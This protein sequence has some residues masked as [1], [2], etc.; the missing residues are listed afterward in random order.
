MSKPSPVKNSP[1]QRW[2]LSVGCS[3][4]SLL[5]FSPCLACG[6]FFPNQ[7]LLGSDDTLLSAPIADF[8]HE[9]DLLNLKP[10]AFKSL[11]PADK[12]NV[13]EQSAA[14]DTADL[15]A[16]L[17]NLSEPARSAMVEQY[18]SARAAIAAHAAAMRD[19]RE[20]PAHDKGPAKPA[21]RDVTLPPNLPPEFSLYATGLLA[22]HEGRLDDARAAWTKLLSLP[23]DQRRRRS[24]WAAYMLG[25]SHLTSDPAQAVHYFELTRTLASH[26]FQDSLGLA[27][28]SLGWQARAELNRRHHRD[29]ILLYLTE[30]A[31]G[32]PTA[33]VS[34]E[35]AIADAFSSGP[36]ALKSLAADPTCR[37]AVSAYLAAAGGQFNTLYK[38]TSTE[39]WLATLE[40]QNITDA[41][42]ADRLALAAYNAGL[43]PLASRWCDRAP[44]APL[45]LWVRS[46]LLLRAGKVDDAIQLLAKT[47]AS[48][49]PAESWPVPTDYGD[50][51]EEIPSTH[52]RAE[53]GALL[54]T[55]GQFADSLDLL[56]RA[57]WW[58][59]AAHV[60]E[61]VLTLD[62]LKGYVD[63]HWP[64][65]ITPGNPQGD[66][67]PEVGYFGHHPTP[68]TT[69]STIRYLLARR[70]TR[71]GRWDDARPY[72][73]PAIQPRFDAYITA[74]RTG[75]DTAQPDAT[76]AAALW[77][78]AQI[79]RN[80]GMELL[81]TE[82]AP[83]HHLYAGNF[84]AAD[85][86]QSR[87]A[88]DLLAA[89][90]AEITRILL[91]TPSPNNRYH[92][93]YTAADHAFA[94]A[95]LLP[96]DTDEKATILTT[97]GRWLAARDPK[98]ADRFYKT[99]VRTCPHTTLGQLAA[100]KHWFPSPA[101][102]AP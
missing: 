29:A 68:D 43:F 33:L 1:V 100:A 88:P 59:D 34:I 8:A 21:L 45:A 64:A 6:P 38:D 82:L 36:E 32:S 101:P 87:T 102:P 12:Q 98:S 60:A 71:A 54:L 79:A 27:A 61:R 19:F 58:A 22:F 62:E 37:R 35:W 75:R 85:L 17:A 93:R 44:D 14:I 92:Y 11:P 94:A 53:L 89:S 63:Q 69:A 66:P 31:A 74:L 91:S 48:F 80:E 16:A 67:D 46:K 84:P 26:D 78:A 86:P 13:Y 52:A 97:A 56:L 2:T 73:P 99:L 51:D 96:D 50:P 76:R 7:L 24:T 72:Y 41:A 20:D 55:R 90:T 40:S 25:K 9:L 83:D 42:G 18:Q 23:D 65:S 47:A 57:S 49:P 39:S 5:L 77:T 81:G 15:R 4:F 70:L 95:R 3:M 30:Y 28:S 10:A